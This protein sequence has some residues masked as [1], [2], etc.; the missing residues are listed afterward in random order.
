MRKTISSY[1]DKGLK[2][3]NTLFIRAWLSP[4]TGYATGTIGHCHGPGTGCPITDGS[5]RG[6]GTYICPRRL[7]CLQLPRK[8][9]L[10]MWWCPPASAGKV[11]I[12]RRSGLCLSPASQQSHNSR[13]PSGST[14]GYITC[15]S[16]LAPTVHP[17]NSPTLPIS[18]SHSGPLSL[19]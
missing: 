11:T 13:Y 8:R 1:P 9:G 17:P 12:Q 2:V 16:H 19:L 7:P 18:N 10:G 4:E 6:S 14:Q 3:L 5:K 15:V